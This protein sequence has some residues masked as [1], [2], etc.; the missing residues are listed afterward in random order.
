MPAKHRTP[1]EQKYWDAIVLELAGECFKVG[2]EGC[3]QA[4]RE[5]ADALLIERRR[6]QQADKS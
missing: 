1:A 3:A 6:S 2:P 5:I 4:L